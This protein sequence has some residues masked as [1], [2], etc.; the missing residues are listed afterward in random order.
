MG[1]TGVRSGHLTLTD[2]TA[3]HVQWI[4]RWMQGGGNNAPYRVYTVWKGHLYY[5]HWAGRGANPTEC[6]CYLKSKTWGARVAQW[7]K[8]RTLDFSSGH[9]LTVREFK[10]CIGLCAERAELAWDSLFLSLPLPHLPL[11]SLK[12]NKLKKIKPLKSKTLI[13]LNGV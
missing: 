11:L 3:G 2:R 9:Y 13:M 6:S 5:V 10:P 8:H 4:S 1:N 12:I 7:V